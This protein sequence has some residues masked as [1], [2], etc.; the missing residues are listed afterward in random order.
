MVY[1]IIVPLRS[2][3]E[4]GWEEEEEEE[5]DK[6]YGILRAQQYSLGILRYFTLFLTYL[7]EKK[8]VLHFIQP[9]RQRL[10]SL[11]HL[12]L[13]RGLCVSHLQSESCQSATFKVRD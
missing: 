10:V 4:T 3:L 7:I 9:P 8:A 11:E 6:R 5:E 1:K 13:F 2:R 12:I